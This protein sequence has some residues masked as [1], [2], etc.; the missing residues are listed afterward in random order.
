MV[1]L[2]LT[3]VLTISKVTRIY[4]FSGG[5]TVAGYL[6]AAPERSMPQAPPPVA[7]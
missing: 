6:T 4:F 2:I 7:D 5:P 1:S 3:V